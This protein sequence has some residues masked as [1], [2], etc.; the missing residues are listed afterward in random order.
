MSN[1]SACFA[2]GHGTI[3]HSGVGSFHSGNGNDSYHPP[4]VGAKPHTSMNPANIVNAHEF[5]RTSN[6][7]GKKSLGNCSILMQLMNWL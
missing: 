5:A 6:F 2:L 7:P 3:D 1:F 4:A